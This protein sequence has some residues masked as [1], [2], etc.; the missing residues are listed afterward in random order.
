MSSDTSGIISWRQC[1]MLLSTKPRFR[2]RLDWQSQSPE[3]CTTLLC[4][5]RNQCSYSHEWPH[6]EC[7]SHRLKIGLIAGREL[8]RQL[9]KIRA[10]CVDSKVWLLK[11]TWQHRFFLKCQHC[12]E[13]QRGHQNRSRPGVLPLV[14]VWGPK[15][16]DLGVLGRWS[17]HGGWMISQGGGA[18]ASG[19]KRRNLRYIFWM[20]PPHNFFVVFVVVDL[21]SIQC[22]K[23]GLG[24]SRTV[25]RGATL[26]LAPARP[27]H[28]CFLPA[29]GIAAT[30]LVHRCSQMIQTV[31]CATLKVLSKLDGSGPEAAVPV[32]WD[33]QWSKPLDD[34][35]W[36]LLEIPCSRFH[37][38]LKGSRYL[39]VLFLLATTRH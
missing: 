6:S 16:F 32:S 23:K 12:Y 8:A 29:L 11:S 17:K 20:F 31:F 30:D 38:T 15:K 1:K 28:G 34:V 4:E 18:G 10:S 14:E 27:L 39:M 21:S 35:G 36:N 2:T 13:S 33:E 26:A 19:A 3:T 25:L 5:F 9:V 24:W 7:L 37:S 22:W